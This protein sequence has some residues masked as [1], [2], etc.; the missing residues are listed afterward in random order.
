MI[1]SVDQENSDLSMI[2]E[3]S[4]ANLD[5]LIH[6]VFQEWVVTYPEILGEELLIIQPE[7]SKFEETR[8]RLDVLALDKHGKLV[9]VELKLDEADHRSEKKNTSRT[10]SK[11]S[12]KG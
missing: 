1:F 6:R 2:R 4:F 9:V 12:L 3:K 7:Y 8:D 5:I 10:S 11:F